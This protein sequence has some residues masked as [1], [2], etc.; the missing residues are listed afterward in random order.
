MRIF[1]E[2]Y[3]LNKT[4]QPN[5]NTSIELVRVAPTYRITL[6]VEITHT[7]GASPTGSIIDLANAL[8]IQLVKNGNFNLVNLN[9][10]DLIL[11]NLA[12]GYYVPYTFDNTPNTTTKSKFT[13]II[14]SPVWSYNPTDFII[15]SD[16][17]SDL[18]LNIQFNNPNLTDITINEINIEVIQTDYLR[19]DFY[20]KKRLEIKTFKENKGLIDGSK[21]V[22]LQYD[23]FYLMHIFKTTE[24]GLYTNNV[25]GF[26]IKRSNVIFRDISK[27]YMLQLNTEFLHP[28]RVSNY[29]DKIAFIVY[30]KQMLDIF[31]TLGY[32]DLKANVSVSSVSN[33]EIIY[34]EVIVIPNL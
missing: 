1:Q 14:G 20:K 2:R 6:N 27:D 8:Q 23:K 13:L 19:N 30:G 10:G 18:R 3:L 4:Y 16:R 25:Q 29:I 32:V 12:F 17:Y 7:N 26:K 24:N 28:A 21:D 31:D 15:A 5:E 9:G 22:D 11:N 33:L 34:N